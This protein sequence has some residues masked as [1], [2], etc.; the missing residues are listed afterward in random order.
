MRA[1]QAINRRE[2]QRAS[3]RQKEGKPVNTNAKTADSAALFFPA[4]VHETHVATNTVK[5]TMCD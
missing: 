3:V 1:Q 5:N 2:Q 4:F